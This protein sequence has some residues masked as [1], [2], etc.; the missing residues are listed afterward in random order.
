MTLSGLPLAHIGLL[1]GIAV[2]VSVWRTDKRTVVPPAVAAAAA[3]RPVR[4]VARVDGG[5][6]SC[7]GN[8][9]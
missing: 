5:I 4:L 6:H 3:L 2:L 8:S 1:L 7:N 9:Q